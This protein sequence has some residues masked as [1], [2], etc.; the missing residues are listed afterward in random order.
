MPYS[1]A[2]FSG[3]GFNTPLGGVA[4]T[5]STIIRS[6]SARNVSKGLSARNQEKSL[7]GS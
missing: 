4:P 1:N 5:D 3:A 6:L 2:G 7:N